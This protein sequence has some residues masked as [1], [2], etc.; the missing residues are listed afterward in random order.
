MQPARILLVDAYRDALFMWAFYLRTRGFD[1]VT[2]SQGRDALQV[3]YAEEPDLVVMDLILP[4]VSGFTAARQLRTD[5]RT[6]QIP[7]IATTGDTHPAHLDE[8]RSIGFVRIMI[9][10]LDPPRLVHEIQSALAARMP[11]RPRELPFVEPER[12]AGL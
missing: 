3:A 8:A 12:P 4:D 5:S 10:P 1:V 9:K 11:S 7:I 6:A 2:A